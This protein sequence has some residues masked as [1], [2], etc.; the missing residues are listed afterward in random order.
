[1]FNKN[2]ETVIGWILIVVLMLAFVFYQQKKMVADQ[3][4]KLEEKK[5]EQIQQTQLQRDSVTSAKTLAIATNNLVDSTAQP[6]AAIT[7]SSKLQL[8]YGSFS[9]AAKG[10]E[11]LFVIENEVEKITLTTKGAQIKSIELKAYKTWDKKP[12]ILFTDKTNSLSYQ[13]PIDDNRVVDTKN[14]YFEPIGESFSITGDTSKSF[15][16]RLNAGNGKYIEQKYTLKGN[17]YLLNYDLN[18][19]GLNSIIPAN[20]TFINAVWENTLASV[21]KNIELERR[22]SALYFRYNKSDVA[23][24]NEDKEEDELVFDTPIEW[25]SYKQQFF[26][27]T[28]FSK[29]EIHRGKLKTHFSK[30]NNSF[31]K[32]YNANFTLPYNN[33]EK[34]TYAFQVYTGPNSYNKLALLDKDVESIIK[35]SP[36]FWMFSWI[37]YITRFIIWVFSWFDSIHLNYGIIILLMTL[38]LKVV[39]HPLTAKSIESAAKMK[40]L[41]PELAA[42]KEKYGEDQGKMGQEQ[43]KLY[44][45]AGVSPFGG[46]LPLLIQMP[47]LM[48][49]YYFFP[50]SVE[51]RQQSFL[52][53]S[54]LSSY[55]SIYTFQKA[56]PLIGD[57]ISLFTILMTITSVLQA[58]MNSQ[59]NVMANQQPGMQ[60]MP[61][62][63]PVM[64]MF[65]F[66][67]FPAAL[68]YYY[69]LQNLL[70][71]A[72]QWL[73]QKFFINEEKLHKQIEEN[74]KNPKQPS[75]WAKKLA[76]VQKQAE[77]RG[78]SKK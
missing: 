67:S 6:L 28:L 72:H 20:S 29:G 63:M 16:L 51:L 56:L 71:V 26:N 24:L 8:Q 60:Y 21:E 14:F 3:K 68:T 44:N 11:K 78:K 42:L 66:N 33:N 13:F 39:L 19:I 10:E 53:A 17:S 1:M 77:Q 47:I 38:I 32:R 40:I 36:D 23:H 2:K 43:M 4:L 57:H 22:Y 76:E 46:C 18:L 31:V 37:K 62:I 61:Y 49:M 74:R 59:M 70:G 52:W 48:A 27:T 34:T 58:V 15:A 5:T 30:E 35:L 73:I 45:K 65:M 69:L 75:G 25:L 9:N 55:D 50:A 41:A 64:L 12:L 7:D 54:D